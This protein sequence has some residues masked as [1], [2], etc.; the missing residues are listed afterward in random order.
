[1]SM[2]N[3]LLLVPTIGALAGALLI[4]SCSTPSDDICVHRPWLCSPPDIDAGTGSCDTYVPLSYSGLK[5]IPKLPDPFLSPDG[6]RITRVDQ[7]PCR[8]A[9]VANEAQRYE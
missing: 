7:W 4:A 9:E 2:T 8:R 3:R 5:A 1:M 6:T